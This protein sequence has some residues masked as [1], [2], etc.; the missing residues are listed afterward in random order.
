MVEK[1]REGAPIRTLS[2]VK[3]VPSLRQVVLAVGLLGPAA[4]G[5]GLVEGESDPESDP[6]TQAGSGGASA[7]SSSSSSGSGG[8][9]TG[10]AGGSTPAGGGPGGGGTAPSGGASGTA[11]SGTGGAPPAAAECKRGIAWANDEATNTALT[12]N[13]TWW[14]NWGA[15]AGAMAPGLEFAPMIWGGEFDVDAVVDAIPA[16]AKTLLGF[17]EPNFFEQADLSAQQAAGAWP[18]VEDVAAQRGL[19]IASPAVNFCGD[20]ATKTGPCHD[21]NPVDYLTEFF[22]NC[23]GCKV[24]YVA[25]HWYNC[26]GESLQWYLDQFKAFGKPLWLTEFACGFGGDTSPAGQ[27]TYMRAA[28]PILEADPAVQRYAWFSGTPI[29]GAR[30]LDDAG[31]LTPLG[32]VYVELP[33]EPCVQ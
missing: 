19:A 26:D 17:N 29:P 9:V 4:C 30:L 5:V 22:A 2:D 10:G 13:V 8:A 32:Q 12:P 25:I 23:Q 20:D 14:Y 21:T 15:G 31:Q 16:G 7:G 28:V 18:W 6:A 33:R 3:D 24:D 11:G 27:E 1:S